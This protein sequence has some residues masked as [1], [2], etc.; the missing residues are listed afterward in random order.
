MSRFSIPFKPYVWA[1]W[2]FGGLGIATESDEY[3]NLTAGTPCVTVE[4]KEDCRVL[5]WNLL[6]KEPYKW[7]GRVDKWTDAIPPLEYKF[8]LQATPVKEM[9]KDRMD[10]RIQFQGLDTMGKCLEKDENGENQL[11]RLAK[12]GVTWLQFHEQWSAVQNY[13][14]AVNEDLL[15][16]YVEEA[17]KRGLKIMV[18]FGYEF[19][20]NAP[21]WQEKRD[22]YLIRTPEGGYVGGWQRKNPC[23]RDYMVCYSSEYSKVLCDRIRYVLHE[24]GVDGIYTD[25]TYVPWECANEKHGCGYVDRFGVRRA[26]FP[27]WAVRRHAQAMYEAVRSKEGAINHTHQSSCMIAGTVGYG[28]YFFN[29]ESIQGSL[30]KG[31]LEFLSLPAL[32]T[33]FMGHNIGVPCQMLAYQ[34]DLMRIEKYNSI[35]LIHDVLPSGEPGDAEY[36]SKFWN[37][38]SAFGSGEAT[39]RPYWVEDCPVQPQTKDVF[40][41]VYEKDG[42][43]LAAVSSFNEDASEVVLKF[44]RNVMVEYDVLGQNAATEEGDTVTVK[45]DAYKPNLIRLTIQ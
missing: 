8:A 38:F 43:Y 21:M 12:A 20:T 42:Q 36:L 44:D 30:Q 28:D 14:L 5:R 29:G 17:H 6:N 27:I 4:N 24:Y 31:F 40:C 45:M 37:E 13:G 3:V 2:E 7:A 32:R 15:R 34:T 9:R 19:A 18:Y 11:D 26:T 39:W 41:S 10:I 22:E 1:G 33:E 25:G 35:S 16:T 23:Q